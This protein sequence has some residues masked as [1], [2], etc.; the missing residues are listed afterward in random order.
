M[1]F[2][3]FLELIRKCENIFFSFLSNK[4]LQ[5]IAFLSPVK[6]TE[7]II[8]KSTKESEGREMD[9]QTKLYLHEP[10]DIISFS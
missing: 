6:V 8:E 5:C 2:V 9:R 3:Y 7:K 10:H 4:Y 1:Q